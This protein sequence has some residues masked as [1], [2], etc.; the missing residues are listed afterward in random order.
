MNARIY[1]TLPGLEMNIGGYGVAT[2]T[3]G[4]L[5]PD[6]VA[7]QFEAEIRGHR[8]DDVEDPETPGAKKRVKTEYAKKETRFRVEREKPAPTKAPAKPAAEAEGKK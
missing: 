3:A 5:V 1:T 8:F 4:V 6:E 2:N 7:D